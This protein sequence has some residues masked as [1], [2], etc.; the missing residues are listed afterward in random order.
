MLI[1]A[2]YCF[3]D[4]LTHVFIL[5]TQIRERCASTENYMKTSINKN[6]E[7]LEVLHDNS[8]VP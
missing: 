2:I 7:T 6:P 4:L 3:R 8:C 5:I 1:F